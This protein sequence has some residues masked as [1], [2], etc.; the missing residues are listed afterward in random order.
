MHVYIF[1]FYF[2]FI[3]AEIL[4]MCVYHN[5]SVCLHIYIYIYIYIT[6]TLL[7]RFWIDKSSNDHEWYIIL[8]KICLSKLSYSFDLEITLRINLNPKNWEDFTL[9]LGLD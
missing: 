4:Y 5:S 3:Y 1:V 6:K 8:N 7:K 9:F 2:H